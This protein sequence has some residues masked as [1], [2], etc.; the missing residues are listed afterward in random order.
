MVQGTAAAQAQEEL[1]EDIA[2]FGQIE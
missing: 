2:K 1:P